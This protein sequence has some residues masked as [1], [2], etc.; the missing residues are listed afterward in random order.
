MSKQLESSS[1]VDE[2]QDRSDA[3]AETA[4]VK[5]PRRALLPIF[6]LLLVLALI[7]A[8]G[9]AGFKGWQLFQAQ[10][11][12]AAEQIVQLKNELAT[13]PTRADLKA[14]VRAM[15]QNAQQATQK[16]QQIEQQLQSLNAAT[17]KLY[18]LYGR[19]EN[20]WK[21]AE[22][23][24]LMSVAQHKLVLENDFAGAARTLNAASQRIA[25]LADP[26]L[27]PVR[28]KINEEIAQLKTRQRPDL[29]G[30][31]L[32][33]AR[34]A[35]QIGSLK[36]GYQ[37]RPEKTPDAAAPR[38]PAPA[39]PDRPVQQKIMDFV[40]SLVT[41]KTR[42]PDASGDKAAPSTPIIDVT[43]TLE[44]N[45]KL[46]R[47]ALL[48]RDAFQYARLMQQNVK[49][50]KQ[51]YDLKNAANA[52]FY[53]ELL[54]LQHTSIKP[55]LPDISGSLQLLKELEKKRQDAPQPQ[56]QPQKEADNG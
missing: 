33:L 21:L 4:S 9:L 30:M 11:Q 26:G 44:D 53:D 20:G 36:P 3:S 13:R 29:V 47:W 16:L 32:T 42:K 37:T 52:E 28:V 1:P 41:I 27:L 22:V 35:R 55:K 2:H 45:L 48:D 10:K 23:E 49:L 8:V 46:T 54:K 43:Q 31:T 5:A 6:T 51:Y 14:S 24:Y 7:V 56:A 39:D 19:D 34:L 50:F 15:Q 12:Q 38:A 17:E 18:E 25:Q 40:G